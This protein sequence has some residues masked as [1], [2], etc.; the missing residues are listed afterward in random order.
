M[1]KVVLAILLTGCQTLGQPPALLGTTP[2][3]YKKT[4]KLL[5]NGK[6]ITGVGTV[7][8][9]DIYR[10]D[11]DFPAKPEIVKIATC[12]KQIV[13]ENPT[14]KTFFVGSVKG[15][16]NDGYCPIRVDGLDLGGINSSAI[17]EIEN[18]TLDAAILCD[19]ETRRTKGVNICQAKAGLT[20]R[21]LFF[22]PV[23]W[24]KMSD[25]CADMLPMTQLG[26]GYDFDITR[27][28]CVYAFYGEKSK[29]FHRLTTVG[30]SDIFFKTIKA[31]NQ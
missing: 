8:L 28:E 7:P 21:I 3:D 24:E 22:E 6:V 16:E 1:F 10:L 11:I 14:T 31:T 26:Y 23:T 29:A 30:Y 15:L 9:A 20:Q 17:I 12:H 18:E 2:P 4:L 27:G 13:L 19:G 25:D 5:V